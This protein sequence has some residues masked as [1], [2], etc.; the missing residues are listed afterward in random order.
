LGI[1]PRLFIRFMPSAKVRFLRD[2]LQR[3]GGNRRRLAATGNPMNDHAVL[4]RW[5]QFYQATMVELPVAAAQLIFT[6]G[7]QRGVEAAA[8]RA[9]E[10]WLWLANETAN[11]LYANSAN[12][13]LPLVAPRN[14]LKLVSSTPPLVVVADSI[15]DGWPH[16][17]R[18][19]V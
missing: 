8:W 15:L 17:G 19:E 2:Q 13:A 4:A 3:L 14:H 11:R 16:A 10:S 9:Y 5:Q 18:I 1:I 7:R 12:R 6:A